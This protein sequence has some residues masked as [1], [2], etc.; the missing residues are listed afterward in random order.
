MANPRKRKAIKDGRMEQMIS[1]KNKTKTVEKEV[2]IASE[3]KVETPK[4]TKPPM[5]PFIAKEIEEIER[6]PSNKKKTT[7]KKRA[8]KTTTKKK[9]TTRKRT[10]LKKKTGD[11]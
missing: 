10:T 8:T 9:A 11:K 2:V 6:I 3:V 4:S 7:T 5:D 1:K